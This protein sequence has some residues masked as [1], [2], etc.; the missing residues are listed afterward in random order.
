M[1]RWNRSRY[2]LL[3]TAL[4]AVSGEVMAQSK[5]AEST[6]I[7]DIVVTAQRRS[8]AVQNVPMAINAFSGDQ[9]AQRGVLEFSDLQRVAPSLTIAPF[10]TTSTTSTIFM[11]GVGLVDAEVPVRDQGVGI[12]VDDVYV[13]RAQGLAGQLIDVERVEVLRGPQGTLYGRNTIGGAVK[14][15]TVK[16]KGEWGFK[17]VLDVAEHGRFRSVTSLDLPEWNGLSA[18]LTYIRADRD[19]LVKNPGAGGD[20]GQQHAEGFRA[21]VRWKPTSALTV[22]YVFDHSKQRGTPLYEQ[23]VGPSPF[24]FTSAAACG[25]PCTVATFANRQDI[26]WRPS[27]VPLADN[28]RI[29]GHSLT[30]EWAISPAFTLKSITSYRT[31]NS[32]RLQDQMDSLGIPILNRGSVDMNEFA[33]EFLL[34]GQLGDLDYVAGADYYRQKGDYLTNTFAAFVTYTPG[35]PSGQ[36]RPVTLSDFGPNTLANFTNISKA[37]FGQI[38]WRPSTLASG[39]SVIV[40]GRYSWDTRSLFRR[41]DAAPTVIDT[42]IKQASFESFDPNV[43]LD[44]AWSDDIHTYA[45]YATAYRAGGYSV[46]TSVGDPA[47]GPEKLRSYELGLKSQFLNRALT[48]NLA[49]YLSKWKDVQVD[50]SGSDFLAHVDNAG[51]IEIRGI[52]GDFVIRPTRRLEFSGSYAYTDAKPD[53]TFQV[54]IAPPAGG[55]NV[56]IPFAPRNKFNLAGS[57]TLPLSGGAELALRVDYSWTDSQLDNAASTTMQPGYGL[58]NARMTLSNIALGERAGALSA[59]VWV[60]NLTDKQYQIY[61]LSGSAVFGEARAAGITVDRRAKGTPLA[62]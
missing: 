32:Q 47:F 52:E 11:R 20:F 27:D 15:V 16:P 14:F 46:R 24:L 59:S 56:K 60:N 57:Y 44:Y 26:G 42:A 7:G 25:G 10:P 28:Y 17:Q 6:S 41:R 23:R 22:D 13:G 12:Y 30:A 35:T 29:D 58:V 51:D 31:L 40:G 49:A 19:G 38:T 55:V 1:Q 8:E 5:P 9:I 61:N 54:K 62:G 36:F 4:S 45:R 50:Y 48:L 37:L 43:T 21:A 34:S 3:A 39:L 53:G 2:I 33:Q 18:K